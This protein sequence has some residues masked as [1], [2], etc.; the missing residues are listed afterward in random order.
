MKKGVFR[1]ARN[2]VQLLL[3]VLVTGCYSFSAASLPGHLQTLS[4]PLFADRSAAGVAQLAVTITEELIE[5]VETRSSLE[6]EVNRD[7]ADAVLEGILVS[8][9]D[10]P[11]QLSSE[12]ERALTNRITIVV[13]ATCLDQVEGTPLFGRNRFTGFADYTAGDYALQQ[14]AIDAS[15]EQIT[16]D[17]F[18]KM[19]S[20]W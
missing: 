8:F 14:E 13:E 12:T 10:E 6:I 18:N 5:T 19:V 1:S 16:E 11:G 3:L 15:L 9:T 4:I 2:A 7:R 20:G 17:I